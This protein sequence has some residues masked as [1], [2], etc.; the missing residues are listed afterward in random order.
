MMKCTAAL[1]VGGVSAGTAP[2]L[3]SDHRWNT[4]SNAA[5]MNKLYKYEPSSF[6]TWERKNR[7]SLNEPAVKKEENQVE[8]AQHEALYS[9]DD[10]RHGPQQYVRATVNIM[11][12][13]YTTIEEIGSGARR[14]LR[15]ELNGPAAAPRQPQS[16]SLTQLLDY[17]L[18]N[19][20]EQ[21]RQQ[22]LDEFVR[23]TDEAEA[24][25]KAGEAPVGN[26][27]IHKEN[28]GRQFQL[29]H[30]TITGVG[31]GTFERITTDDGKRKWIWH[32]LEHCPQEWHILDSPDPVAE[33]MIFMNDKSKIA[34][35]AFRG[36]EKEITDW[37]TNFDAFSGQLHMTS[38]TDEDDFMSV[39]GHEGYIS[40]FNQNRGF[41]RHA[42]H[43]HIPEDYVIVITGHSQGAAL[44]YI[45]ALV[46]TVEFG[47]HVSAV[48]PYASPHMAFQD[49]VTLYE[50]KVGCDGTLH[51]WNNW[52]PVARVPFHMSRP[53]EGTRA[54]HELT[55]EFNIWHFWKCHYVDTYQREVRSLMA[56]HDSV[57]WD[58]GCERQ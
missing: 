47:R 21:A 33:M 38:K 10:A 5:H 16:K 19:R 7:K 43:R 36:G 42:L 49:M 23:V 20:Q 30:N 4:K 53:C 54:E 40:A 28:D 13:V 31:H 1:L 32:S 41:L 44:A 58:S 14:R 39:A 24:R 26:T 37:K 8:E 9:N 51:F 6:Q 15:G 35:I 11:R 48:V 50:E 55:C 57:N 34:I 18:T 27:E 17:E 12:A 2:D 45:G 3:Q 46:T 56:G 29:T 22:E 25:H 52:D